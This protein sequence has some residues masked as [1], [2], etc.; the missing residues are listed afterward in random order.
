LEVADVTP[1]ANQLM[2][3]FWP[4]ALTIVFNKLPTFR[5][6]ALAKQQT[7]AL[8][9]PAN[10]LVVDLMRAVGRP[11][12]GTSANRTG[13]RAPTTA[14][15]VGFGLG[16]MVALIIDGGRSPGG[17]ESTVLDISAGAPRILRE[18]AVTQREIEECL[19]RPLEP[20]Q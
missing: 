5:S 11:L 3:R 12:T 1:I 15:E 13:A 10:D 4:G 6:V 2:S 7:V 9:V 19:G 20:G 16:E 8:R 14:A 18:G 17:V